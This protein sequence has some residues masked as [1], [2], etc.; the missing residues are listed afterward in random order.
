MLLDLS[1]FPTFV[2][3]SVCQPLSWELF[4]SVNA[5]RSV[6]LEVLLGKL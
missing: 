6:S 4:F 3:T 1:F 2:S 5:M